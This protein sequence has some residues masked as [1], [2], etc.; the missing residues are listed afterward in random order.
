MRRR[1]IVSAGSVTERVAE[2]MDLARQARFDG[3]EPVLVVDV[4]TAHDIDFEGVR[5][6]RVLDD[7]AT[8]QGTWAERRGRL[9]TLEQHSVLSDR[10][11]FLAD[12]LALGFDD[13]VVL[14]FASLMDLDLLWPFLLSTSAVERPSMAVV[15]QQLFPSQVVGARRNFATVDL[16]RATARR[17]EAL[18]LCR[19]DRFQVG[20]RHEPLAEMV[21]QAGIPCSLL[22]SES[23]TSDLDR[24]LAV[25]GDLHAPWVN[26]LAADQPVG[27]PLV[28][29]APEASVAAMAEQIDDH[30]ISGRLDVRSLSFLA[31]LS[32]RSSDIAVS[33]DLLD[34]V[35]SFDSTA[36]LNIRVVDGPGSHELSGSPT[37]PDAFAESQRHVASLEELLHTAAACQTVPTERDVVVH[38]A[39]NWG[40]LGCS[41]VFEAQLRLLEMLGVM[42][43][44]IHVDVNDLHKYRP[45]GFL[46]LLCGLPARGAVHRWSMLRESPEANEYEQDLAPSHERPFLSF[47]GEARVARQ[48]MVPAS[49]RRALKARPVSW[50]L[51][52]YGHLMPILRRLDLED[53]PVVCETHDVRAEQHRLQNGLAELDASNVALEVESWARSSAVV[54]INDAERLSFLGH[55]PDVPAITA[56]PYFRPVEQGGE[57]PSF[58]TAASS[59]LSSVDAESAPVS[60]LVDLANRGVAVSDGRRFVLFVG[61]DH[62]ANVTSLSW[63][64]S[65][66]HLRRLHQHGIELVVAGNIA[67]SFSGVSFPGVH[68]LGRVEDLEPLYE[69]ADVSALAVVAG[70]GMP[71]KTIDSVVRGLDFVATSAAVKAVPALTE[72][73][74]TFDDPA[75]YAA[76][77]LSLL[78]DPQDDRAPIEVGQWSSYVEGWLGVLNEAGISTEH[79]NPDEPDDAT[80]L[81]TVNAPARELLPSGEVPLAGVRRVAGA[82]LGDGNLVVTGGYARL[83]IPV[84]TDLSVLELL[85]AAYEAPAALDVFLG[86][87]HVGR[88]V[89]P[90]GVVS[91]LRIDTA[92]AGAS[93]DGWAVLELLLSHPCTDTPMTGGGLIVERAGW[94]E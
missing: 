17:L 92:F 36:S 30:E 15:L 2:L 27:E 91:P 60:L 31:P 8:Y 62:D 26:E 86:G 59:V 18:G 68:F 93:D 54:F 88:T 29:L 87:R 48:T 84:A 1:V 38:I 67:N 11:Q 80:A 41:H 7:S 32:R 44:V 53:V 5:T 22:Q 14:P 40:G 81:V 61:S 20:V 78:N 71:I 66:V 79:F 75:D 4:R 57:P 42:V 12:S 9:L 28:V 70:T 76:R 63:Y 83:A 64:I 74:E 3:F 34:E 25:T 56:I 33:A 10:L 94:L 72:A 24:T 49:L 45:E 50:V 85:V 89:A 51:C 47:E 35:L 55:F 39:P 65:E 82:D 77:V 43:L 37:A 69:A 90:L 58:V 16:L 73:I 19:S 21:E 46:D 6:H 52:N 13:Q 23:R